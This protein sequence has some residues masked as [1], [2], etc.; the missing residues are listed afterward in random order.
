LRLFHHL[1]AARLIAALDDPPSDPARREVDEDDRA[2]DD[3]QQHAGLVPVLE[4]DGVDQ[5]LADPAGADYA[6][7]G[8]R[9]HVDLETVNPEGD[10]LGQHLRQDAPAQG[11]DLVRACRACRLDGTGVDPL[12]DLGGQLAECAH[13]VQAECDGSGHRAEP[14]RWNE[15]DGQDDLGERAD[16]VE[17]LTDHDRRGPSGHVLRAEKAE[18]QRQECADDRADPGHLHRLDHSLPGVREVGPVGEDEHLP[19]DLQQ[20][21]GQAQQPIERQGSAKQRP[22]EQDQHGKQRDVAPQVRRALGPLRRERAGNGHQASRRRSR[23]EMNSMITTITN[24][25]RTI[26]ATLS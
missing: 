22:E 14:E 12:D 19:G 13:R 6:E 4:G 23:S 7:D 3:D 11:L 8:R 16:G 24:N 20:R 5:R 18:R 21:S 2:D 15:E 26:I 25:S 1:A 10:D 9:P 17:Q